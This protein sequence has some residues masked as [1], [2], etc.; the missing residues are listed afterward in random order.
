MQASADLA[1]ATPVLGV[2]RGLFTIPFRGYDMRFHFAALPGGSRFLV[3]VPPD[4]L[5][6]ASATVI[7]NAPIP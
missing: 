6:P 5:P 4:G 2:A 7:L 1:G 3:N